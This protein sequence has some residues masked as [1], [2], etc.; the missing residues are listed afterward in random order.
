MSCLCLVISVDRWSLC[1]SC[2]LLIQQTS[3]HYSGDGVDGFDGGDGGDGVAPP[4]PAILSESN[5]GSTLCLC[6]YQSL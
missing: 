1:V 5:Q 2:H 4:V 6:K 3:S